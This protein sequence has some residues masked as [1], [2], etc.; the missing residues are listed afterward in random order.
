MVQTTFTKQKREL[1]KAIAWI[2]KIR[3]Q[4]VRHRN[5]NAEDE[6]QDEVRETY[7]DY[8]PEEISVRVLEIVKDV[9]SQHGARQK[10]NSQNTGTFNWYGI[11]VELTV[12][13]LRAL[14]SACA[15]LSEL[16]RK[17]PRRNP[18]L[19]YNTTIDHRPA[20]AH[21]KQK[22][23]E[24]ETRYV[25]YEEDSTTRIR[26]YEERYKVITHYT[27][28]IEIDY[29]LEV[30]LIH[31]LEEMVD[32][33]ETAIQVA[34]DEA[35]TKGRENDPVLDNV[36]DRISQTILAKLPSPPNQ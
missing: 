7:V 30:K 27:Q 33:L 6:L 13:Q 16:V 23:E 32:D 8:S 20:F 19:I 3:A 29:G 26:T 2:E 10:A 28:K 35:N 15:V 18:K 14:Q 36:I 21:V 24:T 9:V 34:I 17:L 12:P 22:H 5:Y 4:E 11:A 25:P 1:A 31:E